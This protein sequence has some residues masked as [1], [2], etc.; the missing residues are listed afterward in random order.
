MSR[1]AEASE[2]EQR[3]YTQM[4][5]SSQKVLV[6]Q[7]DAKDLSDVQFQLHSP[8]NLTLL[9]DLSELH[10]HRINKI[11]AKAA[12]ATDQSGLAPAKQGSST[13]D[14]RKKEFKISADILDSIL[15]ESNILST[16]ESE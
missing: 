10:R 16:H 4:K 6:V 15:N 2:N 7:Y 12:E 1:S 13:S 3:V 8:Q 5:E 9:S 11:M 14:K